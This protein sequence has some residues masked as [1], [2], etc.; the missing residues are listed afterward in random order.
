MT[1]IFT[2]M[3]ESVA[4]RRWLPPAYF[5]AVVVSVVVKMAIGGESLGPPPVAGAVLI[6]A[7][8]Y[9]GQRIETKFRTGLPAKLEGAG[10]GGVNGHVGESGIV[11][12]E[13]DDNGL[14]GTVTVFGHDDVSLPGPR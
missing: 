3:L 6:I 11:A 9:A 7:A 5:V 4:A 2:P 13:S 8:S 1:V 12:L 14:G 10:A